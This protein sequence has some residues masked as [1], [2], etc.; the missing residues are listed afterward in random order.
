MRPVA[1][2]AA[3]L[4]AALASAARGATN[5]QIDFAVCPNITTTTFVGASAGPSGCGPA[6]FSSGAIIIPPDKSSCN[7]PATNTDLG[8]FFTTQNP[9]GVFAHINGGNSCATSPP[10]Q[11]AALGEGATVTVSVAQTGFCPT[12]LTVPSPKGP[13]GGIAFPIGN[14]PFG[15]YR[16]T[17]T[18]PDQ[19]SF[20]G[21]RASGTLRV[22]TTFTETDRNALAA[23]GKSATFGVLLQNSAAGRG[24]GELQW[25]KTTNSSA[26]IKGTHYYACGTINVEATVRY[27]KRS[28]GGVVRVAGQ[29]AFTG[30]TGNYEG[31]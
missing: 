30:G 24:A 23:P 15:S 26:E 5:S 25:T 3:V 19:T 1:L 6:V 31:N 18:V 10:T 28:P 27:G 13:F 20:I 7:T 17:L 14:L 8:A 22:G 4:L 16:V 21:S 2:A 11:G 9:L 12:T 29:G